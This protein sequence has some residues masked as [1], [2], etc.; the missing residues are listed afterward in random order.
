MNRYLN[1][2]PAHIEFLDQTRT[3]VGFRV[4]FFA[5][6]IQD[7]DA[8]P[9]TAATRAQN[10]ITETVSRLERLTKDTSKTDDAK[11]E[12]AKALF[13]NAKTE[14][15]K[16]I[17]SFRKYSER[18][19][20]AA[21]ERAFDVLTPDPA[22]KDIY[23]EI[24]A[25]CASRRADADFPTELSKMVAENLDVARAINAGPGFLS[26]VGDDRRTRLVTDALEAFAPD[27]IAHMNHALDVGKEGDRMEVGLR[28]LEQ[29]MFT[30]TLADRSSHS[31][32]DVNA[33]LI[34]P[35]TAAE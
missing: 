10:A 13:Q 12:A 16:S 22:K 4:N 14:V 7:V 25:Y 29:A 30:S 20:N 2:H 9:G 19:A 15:S 34:A 26:G 31:R 28:K 18:E 6:N 21:K 32:V 17:N 33:P 23:S 11:H 27:D 1:S 35:E 3:S 8:V 24:R 5:M